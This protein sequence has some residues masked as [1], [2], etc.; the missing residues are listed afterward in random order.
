MKKIGITFSGG[1]ARGLGHIGVL[2]ALE[3]KGIKPSIISGTSAGAVCGALYAAG[4]GIET[5]IQISKKTNFFSVKNLLIGKSGL[6]NMKAF[7]TLIEEHVPGNSFEDLKKPLYVAATD[8][9]N[10]QTV[11]FSSG[12]L[13]KAIMASACIPMVYEPIKYK[14]SY[15]LDGGILN[16]FPVEIIRD[17]CD[18]LIGSYVNSMS[19]KLKDLHM[20]DMI[21]RSFHLALSGYLTEKAK[22]CDLYIAPEDMSRFSMFDMDKANEIIEFSYSYTKTLLQDRDIQKELQ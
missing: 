8:I 9:V 1:G 12:T 19:L 21:D 5:I 20:K 17:K 10:A 11:Y 4:Y 6:L 14:D 2:K 15:F 3:E 16:N 22:L 18:Y 13:S 7:E